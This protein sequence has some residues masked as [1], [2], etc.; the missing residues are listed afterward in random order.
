MIYINEKNDIN[1]GLFFKDDVIEE[2]L[3]ADKND[4]FFE[5]IINEKNITALGYFSGSF[6][7]GKDYYFWR[8]P[9]G[10]CKLYIYNDHKN[11]ILVSG[12]WID[13]VKKGCDVN[14]IYSLPK[15]KVISL[16]NNVFREIKNINMPIFEGSLKLFQEKFEK[17]IN[18][19]YEK[20]Q[21]FLMKKKIYKTYLALSGGLDSGLLLY[22]AAD[23]NINFNAL[24]LNMHGSEDAILAKKIASYKNIDHH[25]FDAHEED[26]KKALQVAPLFCEDWRDFNVHCAAVNLLL[27]KEITRLNI[28]KNHRSIIIT[29]D[30]MNEY[31]CDYKE[32]E[33][34]NNFYYKL[35]NIKISKLQKYLINGMETSSREDGVFSKYSISTLQPYTLLA[36]LYLSLNDELLSRENAKQKFNI[37]EKNKSIL[38][39][40]SVNK[41]RAQVGSKENMGILGFAVDNDFDNNYFLDTITKELKVE[42]KEVSQL[43][44]G[45]KFRQLDFI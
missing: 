4:L 44:F 5:K 12:S 30:F 3:F 28:G 22:Y 36:D 37:T 2:L 35:P 31:V 10:G 9:L 27:A 20:L 29:G 41:L 11:N 21:D 23:K 39:F 15:G 34:K 18:L 26:I 45:G 25:I 13:L 16:K 14:N 7:D 32:E 43:I 40:I 1:F 24:T 33:F 38:D 6:R 17:R 42:S 19:F 8:D